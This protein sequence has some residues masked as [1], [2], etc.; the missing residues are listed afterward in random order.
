[1]QIFSFKGV[2]PLYFCMML[3]CYAQFKR[4]PVGSARDVVWDALMRPA[5]LR[6]SADSVHRQ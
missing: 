5:D 1:M 6:L 2:V 4:L 3:F